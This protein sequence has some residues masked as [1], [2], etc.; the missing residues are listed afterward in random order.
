MMF[1]FGVWGFKE[2]I[3]QF[4]GMCGLMVKFQKFGFLGGEIIE[5]LIIV[6]FKE[7]LLI[8]EYFIFIYGVCKGLVDIVLKIVDVGYLICCLVDV[9][10]DVIIIE[11]DCEIL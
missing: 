3:C 8:F 2:Q 9:V 4:F 5:N 1:D 7:G 6:N 11:E 10:Q